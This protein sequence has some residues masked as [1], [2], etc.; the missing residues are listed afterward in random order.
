VLRL[1]RDNRDLIKHW[2]LFIGVLCLFIA[3]DQWANIWINTKLNAWT[4]DF[5]AFLLDLLGLRGKSSG[6]Y[7]W[8][9]ICYFEIIGECT[10]F[11]PCAIYISAVAAFPTRWT[12]KLFGIAVGLPTLLLF[13]QLRL[14]SLCYIAHWMPDSFEV[15]HVLVWQSVIVVFTVV[16]W[17]VWATTLAGGHDRTHST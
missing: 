11:Y 12:R 6:R 8:S 4:A 9:S 17:L 15:M 10:A 2:L 14:V 13:N 16:L 5:N 7:V 1:L 3:L